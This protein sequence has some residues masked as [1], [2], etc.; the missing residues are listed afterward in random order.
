MLEHLFNWY[1]FMFLSLKIYSYIW[2]AHAADKGRKYKYRNFLLNT[3]QTVRIVKNVSRPLKKNVTNRLVYHSL[4]HV[5]AGHNQDK[6]KRCVKCN[7]KCSTQC[8]LCGNVFVCEGLCA[9]KFHNV[10]LTIDTG[11]K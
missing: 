2:F 4:T 3:L 7:K 1:V 9:I 5:L 11:N 6:R 10:V 8:T